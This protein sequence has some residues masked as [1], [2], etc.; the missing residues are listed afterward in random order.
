MA[1]NTNAPMAAPPNGWFLNEP[2]RQAMVYQQ[3]TNMK[4]THVLGLDIGHGETVAYLSVLKAVK[5]P[6]SNKNAEP[7]IETEIREVPINKAGSSRIATMIGFAG[8]KV[9]I[10]STAGKAPEFYQHFKVIP[11]LWGKN[12]R[13]KTF[14]QLMKA[15]IHE[16]W[17]GI[18]RFNPDVEMAAKEGKLLIAVGCPSSPDWTNSTA[19]SDYQRLITEATGCSNVT[20]LAESTAAIMSAVLDVNE[21]NKKAHSI[22]LNR[23]LAVIDAGSSTI[24]FTY[25]LLGK[26]L[27]TRSL[28][29]A[30]HDLDAQIL[31]QFLKKQQVAKQQ[32]PVEQENDVMIQIRQIKENF[33]PDQLSLGPKTIDI[34]GHNAQGQVDKE[35]ENGFALKAIVNEE[36][37]N[38]ALNEIMDEDPFKPQMCWAAQFRHFIRDCRALIGDDQNNQLLC[39]KV[40]LTGGTSN[41]PILRD[42][43]KEEYPECEILNSRDCSASVAK[44][45]CFAKS[46][47]IKGGSSVGTYKEETDFQAMLSYEA[48]VGDLSRHM[49]SEV[50]KEF[51]FVVSKYTASRKKVT[52]GQLLNEINKRVHTNDQLSGNASKEKV[53]ELFVKHLQTGQTQIHEKVNAVSEKIYGANLTAIPEVPPMTAADLKK[54]T[55]QLDISGVVNDAWITSIVSGINFSVIRTILWALTFASFEFPPLLTV[56]LP[57]ALLASHDD[58]LHHI[59]QFIVRNKTEVPHWMLNKIAR[60]LANSRKRAKLETDSADKS[61]THMI[62]RGILRSEFMNFIKDQAE[63]A[64]GKVLF[65]V[66]DDRPITQ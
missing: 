65:L 4:Y 28:A 63:M 3:L 31:D 21:I 60:N 7:E 24:D 26:K 29:V 5:K 66:Y 62:E 34:W 47:E 42:I 45:L 18:I 27:I 1:T 59:M 64:L 55:D 2:F 20:V 13:T 54:L 49:A 14:R 44:G 22:Q 43:V 16:L 58:S 57:L 39:D 51:Q 41:V 12:Y 23:G 17:Q 19:V 9:I 11:A 15:F 38:A 33:Y 6:N 10:G 46:L 53:K 50:C 32:I 30:G 52:A 8:E 48:F 35:A 56:F 61:T 37:M 25:V 36:L 40:I